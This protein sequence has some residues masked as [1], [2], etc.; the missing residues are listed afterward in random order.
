MCIRDRAYQGWESIK[1]VV[2]TAFKNGDILMI[3]CYPGTDDRE[4]LINIQDAIQPDLFINMEDIFYESNKLTDLMNFHLT[5]DRVRGIM[6]YGTILDF[7]DK[8]KLEEAREKVKRHTGK[9]LV[10]GFGASLLSKEGTL[11]YA[12]MARW[13][14]QLR[15]R[16]VYKRQAMGDA[17]IKGGL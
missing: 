4:I 5:E 7:I 17:W 8:E 3:D 10:Y 13:E 16:D 9:A 6:Y 11:V 12:D 15:Y 1:T 14:I 2:K